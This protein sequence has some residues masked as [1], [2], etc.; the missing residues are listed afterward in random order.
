MNLELAESASSALRRRF[1]FSRGTIRSSVA[2][3]PVLDTP[4]ILA[5]KLIVPATLRMA[6]YVFRYGFK[7]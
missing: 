4:Q 2:L 7:N 6:S 3:P 1:V 5:R